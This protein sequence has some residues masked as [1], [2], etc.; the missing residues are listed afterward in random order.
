[1]LKKLAPQVLVPVPQKTDANGVPILQ[2]VNGIMQP[3]P[4]NP[5]PDEMV[6]QV[7]EYF[8]WAGRKITRLVPMTLVEVGPE[9]AK[10]LGIK[11]WRYLLPEA[12]AER[13]NMLMGRY[14]TGRI[15]ST[16][17]D[18]IELMGNGARYWKGNVLVALGT[19]ATNLLGGATQYG[20]MVA[21]DIFRFDPR[22]VAA[23]LKAPF[24][25]LTP[26]AVR[27]VPA[28]LLGQNI[29]SQFKGTSVFFGRVLERMKAGEDVSIPKR[30]MARL[31]QAFGAGLKLALAPFGLI[32]NY[33]KRAIYISKME[34]WAKGEAKAMVGSG[35]I[36][37]DQ[38]SAMA[39]DLA[40]T[41]F[42]KRPDIYKE[43]MQGP[44]DAFGMDYG[45][46]PTGLQ[47]FRDST[48]GAA[49]APF[50]VYA[51]K[52]ARMLGRQANAFNPK[53][54]MPM[55]ERIARG[56]GLI[57]SVGVPYLLRRGLA[58]DSEVEQAN[59]Q[60][61]E[62]YP[63]AKPETVRYPYLG[64]REHV[65]SYV[66]PNGRKKEVFL[67]TA[68]YGYLN[69]P[70]AFKSQ[71]DF[72]QFLDEFK[73][74][75]PIVPIFANFLEF[76]PRK[77]GA[78]DLAGQVGEF[79]SGFIP[80]HRMVEFTARVTDDFRKR[81]PKGFLDHL[82]TKI[83]GMR[84]MVRQP[85]DKWAVELGKQDAAEE[86]L[87]FLSGINLK[88]VDVTA[89]KEAVSEAVVRASDTA[90]DDDMRLRIY[91]RY[92]GLPMETIK[93]YLEKIKH[94]ER[95]GLLKQREAEQTVFYKALQAGFDYMDP[96]QATHL[97]KF[98]RKMGGKVLAHSLGANQVNDARVAAR[99]ISGLSWIRQNLG[100]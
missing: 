6:R 93:N 10:A 53:A 30:A 77:F 54:D 18:L 11:P 68:K 35:R 65:Y 3:V 23:D 49:V 15:D 42:R 17:E 44:L 88:T 75:G 7:R 70:K 41:A 1:M 84:H 74:T 57:G 97:D 66:D 67:K 80:A 55:R 62:Q 94:A 63:D 33:L 40:A 83:P 36:T 69:L 90:I 19:A 13:F 99:L 86:W 21:E 85:V 81:A 87:K 50:P 46:I 24:K 98:K 39:E 96:M 92:S 38:Q 34:A 61:R 48:L 59:Q 95:A 64:G 60:F 26:K 43:V 14:R 100:N 47:K 5:T 51:Y 8:P 4:Q 27:D 76:V 45:N 37:R 31:D 71:E 12:M 9:E 25:A 78:R 22:A 72:V 52:Y 91:S 29:R 82:L 56:G 20:G 16:V 73:S 28:E 32:E 79:L 58:G 89:A 2:K